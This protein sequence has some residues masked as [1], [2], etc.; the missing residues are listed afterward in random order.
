M[1]VAEK[2]NSVA[3]TQ[4]MYGIESLL[5]YEQKGEMISKSIVASIAENVA[6]LLGC[7]FDERKELEKQFKELYGIRSKIAHGKSNDISA[8]EV[9]DVIGFFEGSKNN[10]NGFKLYNKIKIFL[11]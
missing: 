4:A 10:E 1:A 2:E 8:Y 3:F 6:F 5:Q 7:N 9:L 11:P